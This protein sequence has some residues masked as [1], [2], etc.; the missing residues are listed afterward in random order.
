MMFCLKYG[1]YTNSWGLSFPVLPRGFL[2]YLYFADLAQRAR[3]Y[4]RFGCQML[5]VKHARQVSLH[6][7][8]VKWNGF[9]CWHGRNNSNL[10][11]EWS[12]VMCVHMC[13]TQCRVLFTTVCGVVR[14][15]GR[16]RCPAHCQP[17][18]GGGNVDSLSGYSVGEQGK[19]FRAATGQGWHYPQAPSPGCCRP[20]N[21]R[22]HRGQPE[23]KISHQPN[24]PP[25]LQCGPS[26]K[27]HPEDGTVGRGRK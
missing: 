5:N 24:P 16:R 6:A 13:V 15:C 10:I 3:N 12:P 25:F 20:I 18:S 14:P 23:L 21:G 11:S 9:G 2:I 7:Q 17:C 19:W 26:D 22:G 27:P 8:F 4:A 1:I